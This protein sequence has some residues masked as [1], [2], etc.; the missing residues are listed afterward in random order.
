MTWTRTS[1][2]S[3]GWMVIGSGNTAIETASCPLASATGTGRQ[4]SCCVALFLSKVPS[5]PRNT[6]RRLSTPIQL[7]LFPPSRVCNS[8]R[9]CT[10]HS[11]TVRSSCPR[12]Q[13]AAI[14]AKGR[15][16]RPGRYWPSRACS[17][18]RACTSH[19]FTVR[20]PCPRRQHAAI[21]AKG[22]R[23]R[24][25][26]YGPPGSAAGCG[27]AHPTASPSGPHAPVAST[28]PSGLKATDQ[29]QV[30]M[31]LQG[32]QQGARA[33]TSH[34]FTVRSHAP[35]ASTRPSGLKATRRDPVGMALQGLQQGAG[36]HIPQLHRLVA[37]S[38]RPARWPSGLK[39]TTAD[40]V[41]YVPRRVCSYGRGLARP[42]ASPSVPARGGQ[43][44]T[45]RGKRHRS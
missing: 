15:R 2:L 45:V 35:V 20:S 38:P 31:A 18:V 27:L 5:S 28:R 34:S 19:S 17:R 39:A 30:G 14:R 33:C 6:R 10:S 22:H 21:R 32:L 8:P 7:P 9:A 12:R 44:L 23:R 29:T 13:H 1:G 43:H 4:L 11:F 24:P 37:R 42:T 40:P 41:R 26:R 16:T 36:L 25:G 3:P